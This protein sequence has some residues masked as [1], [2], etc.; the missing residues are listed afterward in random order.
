MT[1]G[2]G[3]LGQKNFTVKQLKT[4]GLNRKANVMFG[5]ALG[6]VQD[7]GSFGG[8]LTVDSSFLLI[9]I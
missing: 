1:D 2:A 6:L 4:L 3:W 7:I 9:H 8:Y 5:E